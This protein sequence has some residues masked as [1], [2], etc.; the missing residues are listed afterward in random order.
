[1]PDNDTHEDAAEPRFVGTTAQDPDRYPFNVTTP[2][3]A[4]EP[5]FRR[6][7]RGL[8]AIG[9]AA[10]VLALAAAGAAAF[11]LL[12]APDQPQASSSPTRVPCSSLGT[13]PGGEMTAGLPNTAPCSTVDDLVQ[14]KVRRDLVAR[15]AAAL[16]QGSAA[17]GAGSGGAAAVAAPAAIHPPACQPL[18]E[19]WAGRSVATQ[20]PATPTR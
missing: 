8:R 20:A 1:M 12:T 7:R 18:S 5:P 9:G 4:S 11:A 15:C 17:A 10:A 14:Q 19:I 13:T 2:S 16:A 6:A 3:S